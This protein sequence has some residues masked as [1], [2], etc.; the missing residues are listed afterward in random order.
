MTTEELYLRRA[1]QLALEIAAEEDAKPK[2]IIVKVEEPPRLPE[3]TCAPSP[4]LH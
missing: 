1:Q 2:P 3:C 4:T